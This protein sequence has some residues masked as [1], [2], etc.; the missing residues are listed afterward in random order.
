MPPVLTTSVGVPVLTC[1]SASTRAMSD[2]ASQ[3][4]QSPEVACRMA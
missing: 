4:Y 1:S 3:P 2:G